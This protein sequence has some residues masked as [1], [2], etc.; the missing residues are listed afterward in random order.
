MSPDRHDTLRQATRDDHES[1]QLLLEASYSRLMPSAYSS[2]VLD[3][4]L[5]RITMPNSGLIDSGRFYL[6]EN[7]YGECLGCG[8]WSEKSPAPALIPDE[9]GLGHIRHF[10][11]HPLF[12]R[13]GIAHRILDACFREGKASGMS[14][15]A[16][17]SSL[18]AVSFYKNAGFEVVREC[19]IPF[20]KVAYRSVIMT[21]TDTTGPDF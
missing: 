11:S 20:D 1:L 10:A 19:V 7:S 16:C 2:D 17:F 3:V 4:V 5:P 18:N 14:R 15:W 12:L 9:Q 8:G 13:Q 21:R 6:I